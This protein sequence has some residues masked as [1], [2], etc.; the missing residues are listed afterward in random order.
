MLGKTGQ[1]QARPGKVSRYDRQCNNVVMDRGKVDTCDVRKAFVCSAVH[2]VTWHMCIHNVHIY[3]Y[4]HNTYVYSCM[5]AY[6]G[7]CN[8]YIYIYIYIVICVCV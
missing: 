4:I 8:I 7:V 6:V 3:I 2:K 1:G 5:Y